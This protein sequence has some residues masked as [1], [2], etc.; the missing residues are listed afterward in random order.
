MPLR[1]ETPPRSNACCPWPATYR[2]C[3]ARHIS[4]DAGYARTLADYLAERCPAS[5][6]ASLR[7]GVADLD[8][9][10]RALDRV[11]TRNIV[12][13][14]RTLRRARQA[15]ARIQADHRST[16]WLQGAAYEIHNDERREDHAWLW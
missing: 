2:R 1:A 11:E 16:P 9:A 14:A 6:L 12:G 4:S 15:I 7:C 5:P 3:H 13:L 8:D 10:Y